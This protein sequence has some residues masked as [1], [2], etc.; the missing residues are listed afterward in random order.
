M[1]RIAIIECGKIPAG[2]Q[3]RYGSYP[4]MFME[5]LRPFAEGRARFQAISAVGGD[6]LGDPRDFDAYLFTGSRH[7]VNDR[8]DWMAPL[9]QFIRDAAA[10]GR[11]QAGICFG[12][13]IVASAFGAP[14]AKAEA[15]WGAGVQR[16]GFED[17]PLKGESYAVPVFH[18]DQVLR[19]PDNAEIVSGNA[20]CPVGA[21]RYRDVPVMSYQ[22]HPEFSR[23]YLAD[24]IDDCRGRI[25]PEDVAR[26]AHRS[27]ADYQDPSLFLR[28]VSDFL[29]RQGQDG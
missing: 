24:L 27:L 8:L 2:L 10:L 6:A 20:F 26:D 1:Q 9:Q 5:A 15:G 22:F 11:P 13:Q 12:H 19:A 18:Q 28:T 25:L 29:T 23:P 21:L 4:H 3:A 17:G 7:G 14:V 16:Y